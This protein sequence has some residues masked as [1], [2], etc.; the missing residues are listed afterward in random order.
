MV[1]RHEHPKNFFE[2]LDEILMRLIMHHIQDR[3]G[4]VLKPF[5]AASPPLQNGL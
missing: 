4:L 3:L 1:S 2:H 5:R